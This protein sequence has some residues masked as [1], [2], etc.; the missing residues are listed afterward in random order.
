MKLL[1]LLFSKKDK[2]VGFVPAKIDTSGYKYEPPTQKQL[3]YA[4]DLGISISEDMSKDDVSCCIDRT[5]NL[6]SVPAS[7]DLL[8]LAQSLGCQI[9]PY[10]SEERA[11][12]TLVWKVEKDNILRAC[13]YLYSVDCA[14]KQAAFGQG[15]PDIRKYS[16]QAEL[17]VADE[18]AFKSLCTR[19]ALD[20]LNPSKSTICYKKAAEL[21]K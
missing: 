19:E 21:L 9:S 12:G 13:L 18:K 4:R 16:V 20:Y 3:D 6:D 1:D 14:R 8:R 5:L 7:V 15:N 2:K 17:F 10:A 11:I